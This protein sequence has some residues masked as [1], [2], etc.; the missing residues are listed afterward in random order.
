MLRVVL[1]VS[2]VSCAE[3]RRASGFGDGKLESRSKENSFC[4]HAL[5]ACAIDCCD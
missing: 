5:C 1:L 3:E 2:E 4:P